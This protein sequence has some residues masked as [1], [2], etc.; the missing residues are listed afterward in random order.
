MSASSNVDVSRQIEANEN[1]V[2][3]LSLAFQRGTQGVTLINECG[4]AMEPDVFS[5]KTGEYMLQRPLYFYTRSDTVTDEAKNF[6]DWAKSGEADQTIAKA[7]FI[8][9]GVASHSQGPDSARAMSILNA[10]LDTYETSIAEELIK[11]MSNYDRL[12]PTFRFNAGSNRLTPQSRDGLER[13]VNYLETQPAGEYVLV[14]FTDDQGPF[15]ANLNL[16][17]DRSKHMLTEIEAVANGRVDH[18]SFVTTGFGELAPVSCNT[19]QNGRA[20]NRRIEVWAAN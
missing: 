8:D 3:Y 10:G 18:I 5:T 12:S 6:L 9:L 11:E 19:T 16:S 7:G 4:I 15:D 20:I 13:F 2:G 14:G 1:A 17:L